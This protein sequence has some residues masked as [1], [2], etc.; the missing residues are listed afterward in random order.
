M[1]AEVIRFNLVGSMLLSN[2]V[3]FIVLPFVIKN[4]KTIP[5]MNGVLRGTFFIQINVFILFVI[6][7]VFFPWEDLSGYRSWGQQSFGRGFITLVRILNEFILF[8]YIIIIIKSRK[9][10][11]RF[12]LQLFFFMTL[13]SFVVAVVDRFIGYKIVDTLFYFR[14]NLA[15]RFVG[16]NGEPKVFGRANALAFAVVLIYK[17]EIKYFVPLVLLTTLGTFISLSASSIILYFAFLFVIIT[18][19]R[20]NN[21]VIIMVLSLIMGSLVFIP[22]VLD[23]IPNKYGTT[24]KIKQVVGGDV[25]SGDED[26]VSN[27]TFISK[28]FDIFD[29]LALIYLFENPQYLAF[30][31]GPNLISIPA[32]KYIPQNVIYAEEHRIDS[33][34]NNF[35][36]NT[37]ATGGILYLLVWSV[38]LFNIFRFLRNDENA[39]LLFF[40]AMV[41]NMVFFSTLMYILC[42]IALGFHLV[43]R[44]KI[45]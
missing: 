22:S 43:K 4:W 11:L 9:V 10:T 30:G 14:D 44:I 36:N 12:F 16:L 3:G 42:A 20:K 8:Y 17:S 13:L 7:S 26:W 37:I 29:R 39:V 15:G 45:E 18:Y 33:V 32:S 1:V 28:R 41:L 19:R 23:L 34:P 40:I 38:F 24:D 5:E 25:S 27:E 2:V 6:F 35:I 21:V 31:V